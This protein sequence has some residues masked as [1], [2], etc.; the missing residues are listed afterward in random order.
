MQGTVTLPPNH[1]WGMG[2]TGC[3]IAE[4]ARPSAVTAHQQGEGF[5]DPSEDFQG[6]AYDSRRIRREMSGKFPQPETAGPVL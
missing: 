3:V 1:R 2:T 6:T 5:D 4:M